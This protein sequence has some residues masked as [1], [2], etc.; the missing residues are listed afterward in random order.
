MCYGGVSLAVY[1][2]GVTVEL[3]R[4]VHAS[5]EYSARPDGPNPFPD[6]STEHVYWDA[7]S[8]IARTGDKA[9]LRVI[10]DVIAGTSA[11]GIN[12]V[13][14]AKG[15]AH[16]LRQDPLRQVWFDQASL[17]KLLLR[18]PRRMFKEGLLPPLTASG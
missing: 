15:L 8:E 12:G 7:L 11:G 1:M 17:L 9:A 16:G 2:H 4:L 13:A 3:Q 14:L 6:S 18:S 10:I 5:Y